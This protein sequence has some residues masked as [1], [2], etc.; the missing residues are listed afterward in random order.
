MAMAMEMRLI[1]AAVLLL[2]LAADAVAQQPVYTSSNQPAPLGGMLWQEPEVAPLTD[3]G[4]PVEEYFSNPTA[5]DFAGDD[6]AAGGPPADRGGKRSR[7]L[8]QKISLGATWLAGDGSDGL[9]MTEVSTS[10]AVIVPVM[11]AGSPFIVSPSL[12]VAFLNGPAEL[13]LPEQVYRASASIMWMSKYS[14][15]LSLAVAIAPGVSSDFEATDEAFR[16]FGFV[17]ATYQWSPAI[18][19]TFGAAYTGRNDIPVFPMA[20]VTWTPYEDLRIEL[21]APR[22]RI[23]HRVYGLPW[24]TEAAED[25]AYFAGELGG[26]TWAVERPNGN[27]DLLTIRDYRILL[28]YERKVKQGV[29]GKL[30][31][32]YV[33]GREIEFDDDPASFKP[34]S[35][36]VIRSSLSF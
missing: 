1:V 28:G 30:E 36:L 33:F 18:E 11:V 17:A 13:G 7:G 3:I 32:G 4:R 16:L 9:Q 5:D 27:Q 19:L 2:S 20:G 15:T 14:E 29:S 35:T 22:P 26:G 12:Q 24:A 34:S 6:F 21:T 23:A 31:I 25:W 10:A 8:L